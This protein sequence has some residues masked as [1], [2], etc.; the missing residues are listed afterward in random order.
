MRGVVGKVVFGVL[1]A[2]WSMWVQAVDNPLE[3]ML[4]R[5]VLQHNGLYYAMDGATNGSLRSS[6]NLIEWSEPTPVFKADVP[7]SYDLTERNGLFYLHAPGRGFAVSGAP[8]EPFTKLHKGGVS[9]RQMRVFQDEGGSLFSVCQRSAGK[10]ES[11]IGLQRYATPWR[12]DRTPATLLDGRK[13][14]WDAIAPAQLGEPEL[15]DYRGNYYLLYAAQSPEPRVGQ[16]EIGVAVADHPARLANK[17]KQ[18]DPLLMRNTER[19]ART[20]QTLLPSGEFSAWEAR[21]TFTPPENGWMMAGYRPVGWRTGEGGFG[22]PAELDGVALQ[23]VRTEWRAHALW[24]RRTFEIGER[25][26]RPVLN[27]RHDAAVQVWLNGRRVYTSDESFPTYRTVDISEACQGLFRPGENLLAVQAAVPPSARHR[28]LDF[29]L[30][31]A[32][33]KS[34]EPTVCGVGAPRVI[35]GPN[36][37]EKWLSY[38]AWWNGVEGTGLDRLFFFDKEMV[39]DGPTTTNTPGYHP[40]PAPPSFS[41]DFSASRSAW[42]MTGGVWSLDDGWMSQGQARGEARALLNRPPASHYLFDA[43]IRFPAAGQGVVGAVAWSNEKRSLLIGINAV[44]RTWHYQLLPGGTA[45]R[46]DLPKGFRFQETP[47]GLKVKAS[48]T[49]RLRITKNGGHFEVMLDAFKLTPEK[50]IM[51]DLT[52]PGVPGLYCLNAT[53]RFDGV[54]YTTGWDEYDAYITGWGA[55]ADQ[56]APGGKWR[57][58]KTRGLVQERHSVPGRAFKGDRLGQY[59]FCVNAR[60]ELD[61]GAGRYYGVFPVFAD[62]NNY[63]KAVIDTHNRRLVLSGKRDGKTLPVQTVSLGCKVPHRH[64]YDAKTPHRDLVSWTYA[65]RSRSVV[66]G[67]DIRW[68]E[69]EYDYLEQEFFIPSDELLVRYANLPGLRE[70]MLW[71]DGR[72]YDADEP[73]P[74]AQRPGVL[75]PV[76]I[77]PER[78]THLAF[79]HFI[80]VP[81]GTVTDAA[82]NFLRFLLPGSVLDEEAGEL[83]GTGGVNLQSSDTASRPQ[84]TLVSIEVES[85]YFFRCVKLQDRVI[86]ELNGRPMLTVEGEWPASQVGLFTEGQAASF[87]GMTLMHLPEQQAAP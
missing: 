53:A 10:G 3:V 86:I 51:T 58:D 71:D 76:S 42:K 38:R 47:P 85:S 2:G 20:Y 78:A 28:Y 69:G 70:P 84:E 54:V 72:F 11:S 14:H 26:A 4:D 36:G 66:G 49:H 81:Y 31:D 43:Q 57:H 87:N 16:R 39:V 45:Q 64:L 22:F 34:V 48:P 21:Y 50:P 12:T 65:L 33:N 24:V 61:E 9:G 46:F 27:I 15:L 35:T 29:G 62:R 80:Y 17:H 8:L 25:P 7:P 18:P 37:F 67:L 77:R 30:Y 13:G 60:S 52:G 19:L 6:T 23:S 56:T 83:L 44:Q 55:A 40:P 68:L 73:K 32:G 59:E 63:L 1:V 41:D 79:G 75:N 74:K 5:A 82:G